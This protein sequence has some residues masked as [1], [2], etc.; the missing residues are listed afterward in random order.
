MLNL[1]PH[2]ITI[3]HI[4]GAEITYPPSG[5]IARVRTTETEEP[6]FPVSNIVPS[7]GTNFSGG[8]A[9][10]CPV[11]R[12]TFSEVEGLPE[13]GTPCLVASLVLAAVPG[14]RNV[15]APDT[16]PTA[17]RDDMGR[18]VAVTRLVVA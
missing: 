10:T 12:R 16:G 14:R 5:Q 13:E 4:S 3:R 11:I 1:T 17:V 8:D 9:W 18:I 7:D 2:P 15:Y 6:G